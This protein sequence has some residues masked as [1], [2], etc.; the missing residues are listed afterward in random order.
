VSC[1]RCGDYAL[2]AF[3]KSSI[4][5]LALSDKARLA[6]HTRNHPGTR[7]DHSPDRIEEILEQIRRMSVADRVERA[8]LEIAER[9]G[10]LGGSCNLSPEDDAPA[11]FAIDGREMRHML[12]HWQG[13]QML[14]VTAGTQYVVT[15]LVRGWMKVEEIRKA[16][17]GKDSDQAFIAMWFDPSMDE[18]Y[19][20]GMKP[21]IESCG[22]RAS[23]VD[24]KEDN[25]K[26]C[27]TIIA[28]IRRSRFVV[29]DFTGQRGGVYYEAG[30]AL[31]LGLPVIRTC[32][33]QKDAA[34]KSEI[35]KLHFDTRQYRH[36]EW[37]NPADLAE[38]L[39]RRIEATII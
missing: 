29:A 30:F 31:G 25:D 27:D 21:A 11:C 10:D 34:G 35:D 20:Q 26:I 19:H 36:I 28:E 33:Q 17:K 7:F 3:L 14:E 5:G 37:E 32:R 23:R 4:D 6:I 8:L 9:A 12:E 1:K 24:M 16:K 2:A 38:K 39:K 22:F 18:A 13:L 15:L